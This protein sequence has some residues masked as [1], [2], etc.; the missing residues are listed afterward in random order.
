MSLLLGGAVGQEGVIL[1][2][3]HL[4]VEQMQGGARTL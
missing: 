1:V 2:D 3:P 4:P